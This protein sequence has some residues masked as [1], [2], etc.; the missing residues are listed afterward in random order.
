MKLSTLK[1]GRHHSP[2]K[3]SQRAVKIWLKISDL[4]VD[5]EDE[6]LDMADSNPIAKEAL[7]HL[8]A[9]DLTSLHQS[10]RR[11]FE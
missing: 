10:L 9:S 11:I 8:R 5:L 1:E 2:K 3:A 6:L 4:F 7:F